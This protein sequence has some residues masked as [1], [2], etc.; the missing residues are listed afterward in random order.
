MTH[1]EEGIPGPLPCHHVPR[2]GPGRV[3]SS[4]AR[5]K[6]RQRARESRGQG[7]EGT[8][9]SPLLTQHLVVTSSPQVSGERWE[10]TGVTLPLH[11]SDRIGKKQS[12]APGVELWKIPLQGLRSSS[13]PWLPD[14]SAAVA[15]QVSLVQRP[16]HSCFLWAAFSSP[17]PSSAEVGSMGSSHT[18]F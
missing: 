2:P 17:A 10:W 1:T 14:L 7:T 15:R 6:R 11:K 9:V 4:Q 5:G 8:A 13:P 16:S 3:A 12:T 18:C